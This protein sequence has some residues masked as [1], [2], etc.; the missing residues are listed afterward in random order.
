VKSLDYCYAINNYNQA[1]E[2]LNLYKNSKKI[3][4]FYFKYNLINRLS[5]DWLLQL[6]NMLENYF[7]TKKFKT[8]IEVKNNYGLFINLVQNKINYIDV[9]A[10][11]KM[12]LK[13]KSIA[14]INKVLINPKFSI[15]DLT[16]SKNIKKKIRNLA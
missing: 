15:L 16:K 5:E 12:L 9:V 11:K 7:G 1:L 14:K 4:I 6:I 8:Y 13:L 2:V 3:P 10:D